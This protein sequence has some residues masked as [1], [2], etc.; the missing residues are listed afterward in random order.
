[1]DGE[2]EKLK[3]Y[4]SQRI[5]ELSAVG[6]NSSKAELANLRRGIGKKPGSMPLLWG[7]TLANISNEYAGVDG[8]PTRGEWAVYVVLTLYALHQQGKDDSAHRKGES[9]GKAVRKL[10]KSNGDEERIKRRFDTVATSSDLAELSNHLRGLVQLMRV[11]GIQIDYVDLVKDLYWFQFQEFRDKV[12]L[13][14]GRDFY[15]INKTNIIDE[16]LENEND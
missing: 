11:E 7:I 4:V 16:R 1:M 14:W 2:V 13:R 6:R 3:N 15:K 12:R 9:L 5:N 10:V 8:E